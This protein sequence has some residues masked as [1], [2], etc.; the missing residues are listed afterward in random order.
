MEKKIQC[1]IVNIF[2]LIIFSICFGCSKEPSHPDGS[3][4]YPQHMF[5]LKNKKVIFLLPTLN[6]KGLI[7]GFI[8]MEFQNIQMDFIKSTQAFF[9]DVAQTL[10][11]FFIFV[12]IFIPI[13]SQHNFDFQLSAQCYLR[14]A[15]A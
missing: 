6:L 2:L 13:L 9:V 1:K 8:I 14:F 7:I 15:F 10:E 4:E 11:I 3:F 12:L 5:W